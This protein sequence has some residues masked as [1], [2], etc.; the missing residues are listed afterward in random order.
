MAQSTAETKINQIF[1]TLT[2][3]TGPWCAIFLG[4]GGKG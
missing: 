2:P 1:E 3:G 4:G